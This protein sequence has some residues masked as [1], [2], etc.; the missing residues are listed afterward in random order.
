MRTIQ[1]RL[2]ILEIYAAATTLIL[3]ALML[4]GFAKPKQAFEEIDVERLNVVDKNG[5]LRLVIANSERMPD[6]IINGKAFKTE[7][8]PDHFLQRPGR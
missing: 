1:G 5:Q 7:R 4:T 6:P 8:S 3:G 2:R